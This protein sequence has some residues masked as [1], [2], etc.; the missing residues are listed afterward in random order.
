MDGVLPSFGGNDGAISAL[1]DMLDA[2]SVKFDNWKS[3]F[4]DSD[5]KNV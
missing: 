5:N 4:V 2:F 3:I 1:N